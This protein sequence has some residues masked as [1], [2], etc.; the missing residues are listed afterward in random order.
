M[1]SNTGEWG[2]KNCV[3]GNGSF[4]SNVWN[5]HTTRLQYQDTVVSM[6]VVVSGNVAQLTAVKQND[7]IKKTLNLD[8]AE[9][10]YPPSF[11]M[12]DFVDSDQTELFVWILNVHGLGLPKWF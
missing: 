12:A 10:K 7:L 4:G 5:T 3:S 6:D 8:G 1:G 11:F 9:F 2:A